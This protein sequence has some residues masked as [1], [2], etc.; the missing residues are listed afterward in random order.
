VS[1]DLEPVVGQQLERIADGDLDRIARLGMW[2]AAAESKSDEPKALGMSAA[3]RIAYAQSLGLPAHA[4][5]D[6]YL[7]KGNLTLSA[8]MCRAL[9]IQH[10]LRVVPVEETADSCTAA[11]IDTR[12]GQELGRRTFTLAMAKKRGLSGPNWTSMPDRMLWARASK[13]ALDDLAPW[14]T[15]GVLS[16]EQAEDW[17]GE[18][19]KI[20]DSE[21]VDPDDIPFGEAPE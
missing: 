8:K 15:V 3:L 1:T 13:I 4:A 7:I 16:A 14:V 12:T 20:A 18:P 21:V 11:V 6:V 10:G 19:V 2:L 9:A 5:S 17:T